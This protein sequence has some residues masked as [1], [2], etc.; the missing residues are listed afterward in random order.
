MT[1]NTGDVVR[2]A[3]TGN[4]PQTS[5]YQNVW[6]YEMTSGAGAAEGDFT[7]AVETNYI[8][9]WANV[10]AFLHS[11]YSAVSLEFWVRDPVVHVWNGI[12]FEGLSGLVGASAADPMPHGAAIVGRPVTQLLRRQGR[13]FLPGMNETQVDLGLLDAAGITAFILYMAD[14]TDP[15]SPTGGVFT[16]CT[17]NTDITSPYYETSSLYDGT[18]AFSSIVGYQRRRKPLVGI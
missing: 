16:W 4:A 12:G 1:L 9:A 13:T 7:D 8:A 14:F 10:A 3:L 2:V 6:H 11:S 17:Y 5:I 18:I 15:I